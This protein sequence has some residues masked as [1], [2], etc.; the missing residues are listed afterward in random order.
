[1]PP[2]G[3]LGDKS[4]VMADAHGCPACPH[5]AVGPAIIGSP[6]VKVNGRPALRVGD[7]GMHTACCNSN[8]W[9]AKAGSPTVFINNKAAHREGDEVTHC[10]GKGKLIEGSPNVF[11]D[12]ATTSGG[13]R[14]P[15]SSSG[16]SGD[17][18]T[19]ERS[20]ARNGNAAGADGG[21]SAA[22]TLPD[23][24]SLDLEV[25]WIEVELVDEEGAALGGI[26]VRVTANGGDPIEVTTNAS[27]L[28]RVDGIQPGACEITLPDHDA[29]TWRPS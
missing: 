11:V 3:R 9:I 2:Q 28:A 21:A 26:R 25:G 17:A 23:A 16:G 5:P 15:S 18:S 4:Q 10:G 12:D 13:G 22:T 14:R 20:E 19:A 1:M 27:G 29:G 24:T 6:D 7:H 8:T